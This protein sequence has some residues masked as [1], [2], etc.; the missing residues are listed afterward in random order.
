MA[1]ILPRNNQ[2][3]CHLEK[4]GGERGLWMSV[5]G[6]QREFFYRKLSVNFGITMLIHFLCSNQWKCYHSVL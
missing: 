5:G 6:E 2:K 1:A 4:G 3:S